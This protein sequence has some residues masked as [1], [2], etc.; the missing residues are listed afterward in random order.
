MKLT[1]EIDDALLAELQREA[2]SQHLTVSEIVQPLLRKSLP[3]RAMAL[4]ALPRFHS[5]GALV[6]AANRDALF[7]AMDEP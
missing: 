3:E 1:I 5:G 4:A 7:K 2:E 6:D